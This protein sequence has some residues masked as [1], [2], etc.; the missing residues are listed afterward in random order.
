[1]LTNARGSLPDCRRHLYNL[2]WHFLS[3]YCLYSVPLSLFLSQGRKGL[4]MSLLQECIKNAT[5]RQEIYIHPVLGLPG[6]EMVLLMLSW[7]HWFPYCCNTCVIKLWCLTSAD[8]MNVFVFNALTVLSYCSF[9]LASCSNIQT[10]IFLKVAISTL[11]WYKRQLIPMVM[12]S[13]RQSMC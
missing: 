10:T 12:R 2:Q 8:Y 11:Q 7:S 3:H 6:N 4:P 1:M 13:Q 9:C 5:Q